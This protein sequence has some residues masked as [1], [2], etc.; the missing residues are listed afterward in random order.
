MDHSARLI[1]LLLVVAATIFRLVRYVRM[2]GAGGPL[3]A[4][5]PS[6]GSPGPPRSDPAA[7]T[8]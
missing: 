2:S 4:I 6:G 3:R 8:L 7:A 1:G 5:P